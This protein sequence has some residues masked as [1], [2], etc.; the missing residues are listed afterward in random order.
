MQNNDKGAQ[1]K[2]VEL[3]QVGKSEKLI[4]SSPK[5]RKSR[6]TGRNKGS[7][8]NSKLTKVSICIMSSL[9]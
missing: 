1:T 4:S 8:I 6:H 3:R 5:E 7:V 2:H 9:D